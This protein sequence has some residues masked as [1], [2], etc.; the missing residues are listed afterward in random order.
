MQRA[1]VGIS[2]GEVS[3][4]VQLGLE[5]EAVSWTIHGLESVFA[6]A[7]LFRCV[8]PAAASLRLCISFLGISR[9]R[10]HVIGVVLQVTRL[11][12]QRLLVDYRRNDFLKAIANV[13]LAQKVNEPVE[14]PRAVRQ[15]YRRAGAVDGRDEEFL[16]Q[17]QLSVVGGFDFLGLLLRVATSGQACWAG[18]L[19]SRQRINGRPGSP[20][21]DHRDCARQLR[22][23][24]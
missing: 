16:L 22:V 7:L 4:A 24:G 18:P 1:E 17:S 19:R 23:E 13:L 15:E 3:V 6:V 12:P 2:N 10:I 21:A 20:W 11:C 5:D 8:L 14:Y 9:H